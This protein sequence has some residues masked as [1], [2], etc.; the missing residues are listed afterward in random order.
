[1]QQQGKKEE[2]RQEFQRAG[3]LDPHFVPPADK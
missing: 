2:A 1:L 3:E